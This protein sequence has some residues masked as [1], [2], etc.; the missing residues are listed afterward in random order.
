M[1]GGP[2]IQLYCNKLSEWYFLHQ[3]K[4]MAAVSMRFCHFWTSRQTGRVRPSA[5]SVYHVQLFN[6]DS[7]YVLTVCPK[8]HAQ[9][10]TLPSLLGKLSYFIHLNLSAIKRHDVPT[11]PHDSQGSVAVRWFSHLPR[12]LPKSCSF[13]HRSPHRFVPGTENPSPAQ[14]QTRPRFAAHGADRSD[15]TQSPPNRPKMPGNDRKL[16]YHGRIMGHVIPY[17]YIYIYMVIIHARD[18]TCDI[19]IYIIVW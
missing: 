10:F 13:S 2:N 1:T 19:Y 7:S 18:G 11:K 5:W 4:N 12:S 14:A 17:V 3:L 15:R 8:N 9:L 6:Y 16:T